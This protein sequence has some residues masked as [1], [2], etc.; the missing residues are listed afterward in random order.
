MKLYIG[1]IAIV[2]LLS[3]ADACAAAESMTQADAAAEKL[4]TQVCSS[5]HGSGGNS[6]S[7]TF[8]KLAAQQQPYLVVQIK[9][10]RNKTRGEQ[11]AHDYMLGMASLIDDETAEALGRFFSR[12]KPPRG[13]PGDPALIANGK[14]LFEQGIADRNITACATCHGKNAEG[15][16]IFPR[17]AG[18]HAEYILRQ[19]TVIQSRLRESPV[20]HGII[21]DLKPED[22]KAVAAF[23]Q[24]K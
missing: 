21:R 20:M 4:A 14:K 6:T 11:E 2:L 10:F 22:M 7:P 12:Q 16:G 3:C 19:L 15:N 8:P 1:A 17:L 18:Q 13:V 23:L 5:C 24:S 9:A